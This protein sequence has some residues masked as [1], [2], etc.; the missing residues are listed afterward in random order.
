MTKQRMN[1]LD[2]LLDSPK[3]LAALTRFSSTQP[4]YSMMLA[5]RMDLFQQVDVNYYHGDF[6]ING[7]L[8]LQGH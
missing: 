3:S 4:I 6:K 1:F 5:S 8:Q 2:A 7:Y